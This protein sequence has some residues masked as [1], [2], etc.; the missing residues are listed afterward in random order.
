VFKLRALAPTSAMLVALFVAGCG[1][2]PATLSSQPA[3]GLDPSLTSS[4]E[5]DAPP[6]GAEAD[7]ASVRVI[8]GD[9]VPDQIIVGVQ[10]GHRAI[11]ALGNAPKPIREFDL[12]L[13]Y[14]VLKLPAGMSRDQA[15]KKLKSQ[16]G[17]QVAVPNRIYGTSLV[18]NDPMYSQQWSLHANR[19]N[20]EAAWDKHVDASGVTVAVIDT[21]VDYGHP[22]LA[23][24][25]IQGPNLADKTADPMDNHGHG[26]HVAGIIGAAGNNGQGVCGVSWNCKILA[27]KVLG[28]DGSGSTDTV[29]EGIKYAV[30]HG[31]KVINLSLGTSDP[32]IDPVVHVALAYAHDHGVVTIAAAGN[33]HSEVGSPAND[34][35]AIA[36]SST[37]S[38]WAFEWMSLFSNFGDKVE[39][40]APGGGILS[41]LPTHGSTVGTLYG[42]L[43]GTSMAA[44]FV[45]GEAALIFAQHPDWSADQVRA[46]IDQAVD[47]KGTAGRNTHYG[48]GRVNLARALD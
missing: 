46:R 5:V 32:S 31:A 16:P 27:I 19:G 21:G 7:V 6:A 17:V 8:R 34:P 24:R 43:S 38:F 25:V 39:V 1:S 2:A 14:Q 4:R 22:D 35:N 28:K 47:H 45:A 23:G 48:F 18:P 11:L 30:D 20:G 44:P 9:V 29:V 37:S 13:H 36:V 12:G 33:S 41:T 40:A 15:I 26:T 42:K 3:T 10:P